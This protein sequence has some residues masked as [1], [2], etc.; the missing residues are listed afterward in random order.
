MKMQ[1]FNEKEQNFQ[2]MRTFC[3]PVR[4]HQ[5]FLWI[6]DGFGGAFVEKSRNL[7]KLSHF[8]EIMGILRKSGNF[9]KICEFQL[10]SSF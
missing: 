8:H 6:I 9:F 3:A 1:L 4:K 5:Y 2:E 10:N 7:A